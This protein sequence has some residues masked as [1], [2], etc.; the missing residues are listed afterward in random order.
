MPASRNAAPGEAFLSSSSIQKRVVELGRQKGYTLV[1]AE[2]YA[3]NAFFLKNSELPADF[4]ER[5]IEE[6][7]DWWLC[8]EPEDEWNRPWVSI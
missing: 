2:G 5:P 7:S 6:I 1:H 3:P 4:V 8:E